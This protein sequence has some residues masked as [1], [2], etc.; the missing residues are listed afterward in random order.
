MKLIACIALFFVFAD[1]AIAAESAMGAES[2]V[3]EVSQEGPFTT[4]QVVKKE[5]PMRWTV[6]ARYN[7]SHELLLGFWPRTPTCYGE[8]NAWRNYTRDEEFS[9]FTADYKARYTLTVNGRGGSPESLFN[10]LLHKKSSQLELDG[11]S[12]DEW[13]DRDYS[14]ENIKFT[15]DDFHDRVAAVRNAALHA[16]NKVVSEA[17]NALIPWIIGISLTALL[18]IYVAVKLLRYMRIALPKVYIQLIQHLK[19]IGAFFR[20][21]HVQHLRIDHTIQAA[22][23]LSHVLPSEAAVLRDQISHALERGDHDA[24]KALLSVLQKLEGD[25]KDKSRE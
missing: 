16:E 19:N 6:Q 22:S 1:G 25:Y 10:M 2:A 12:I 5:L 24:A 20:R 3:E 23:T 15:L 21:P 18:G 14:V 11:I 4:V 17:R 13:R 7:C 9:G 8:V